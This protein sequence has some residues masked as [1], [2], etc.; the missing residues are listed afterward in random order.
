[1]I[2]NGGVILQGSGKQKR[3]L[4]LQLAIPQWIAGMNP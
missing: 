4:E 1:L 2:F 3:D